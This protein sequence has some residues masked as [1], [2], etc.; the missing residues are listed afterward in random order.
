M[1]HLLNE[2]NTGA[3]GA[4]GG[5]GKLIHVKQTEGGVPP[6]FSAEGVGRA[7][8]GLGWVKFKSSRLSSVKELIKVIKPKKSTI[9]VHTVH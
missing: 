5:G 8:F 7:F 9:L 1:K 2:M 6:F 3:V 4:G